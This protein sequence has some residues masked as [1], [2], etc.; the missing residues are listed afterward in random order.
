[1]LVLSRKAGDEILI[2]PAGI[3]IEISKI[4]GARGKQRVAV[5][6]SAPDDQVISRGELLPSSPKFDP[7]RRSVSDG[8]ED[9]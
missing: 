2:E 1:M 6:I 7:K 5:A 4:T 3:R 9:K 8:N